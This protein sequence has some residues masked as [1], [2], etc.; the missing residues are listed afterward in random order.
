MLIHVGILI[1]IGHVNP[2]IQ[3]PIFKSILL[4]KSILQ[5]FFYIL[6]YFSCFQK[7]SAVPFTVSFIL[8]HPLLV[9]VSVLEQG[10]EKLNR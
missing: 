3:N 10:V 2:E 7:V 6:D 4:S 9:L 8:E 5:V 1:L